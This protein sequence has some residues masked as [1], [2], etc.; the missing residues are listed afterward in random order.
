[1]THLFRYLYVCFPHSTKLYAPLSSIISTQ[2]FNTILVKY[3][4]NVC[5]EYVLIDYYHFTYVL[6]ITWN[7]TSSNKGVFDIQIH[8]YTS[9]VY[10]LQY[11]KCKHKYIAKYNTQICVHKNVCI[12]IC[13]VIY[14]SKPGIYTWEKNYTNCHCKNQGEY[15]LK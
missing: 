3:Q 15:L 2:E 6:K 7:S 11:K 9:F 1:M 14:Y 5:W 4:T 8:L 12:Y 13:K 10:S